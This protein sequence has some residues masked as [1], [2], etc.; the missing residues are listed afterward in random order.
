VSGISTTELYREVGISK[1][2]FYN[3]KAKYGGLEVENA[4]LKKGV[5]R[6]KHR[7]LR[8]FY[9]RYFSSKLVYHVNSKWVIL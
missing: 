9:F 8:F 1:G 4:K 5:C 6:S 7:E 3:W 2:T